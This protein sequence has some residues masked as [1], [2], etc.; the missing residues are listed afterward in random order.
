MRR[1]PRGHRARA[2]SALWLKRLPLHSDC[3]T[4]RR[5]YPLKAAPLHRL[6]DSLSGG[7][8]HWR[9]GCRRGR[10]CKRRRGARR[11][12]GGRIGGTLQLGAT[13]SRRLLF[14]CCKTP[15]TWPTH[16][17]GGG[18]TGRGGCD[19]GPTGP[20]AAAAA[21]GATRPGATGAGTSTSIADTPLGAATGPRASAA[22][23][24]ANVVAPKTGA[25]AGAN[26]LQRPLRRRRPRPL[27]LLLA[28]R[29]RS[30]GC[31]RLGQKVG[32]EWDAASLSAARSSGA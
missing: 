16:W 7:S 27:P 19:A 29:G 13:A 18:V 14:Y 4:K 10:R 20:V 31:L 26:W 21:T 28:L 8:T 24:R 22:A 2:A 32:S 25:A 30:G 15:K 12:S 5:G 9:C 23:T 3:S 11:A 17:L 1:G 6:R